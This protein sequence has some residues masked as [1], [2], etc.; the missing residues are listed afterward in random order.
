MFGVLNNGNTTSN[1][2]SQGIVKDEEA[3]FDLDFDNTQPEPKK[4]TVVNQ[5]DNFNLLDLGFD[6]LKPTD[7]N[8]PKVQFSAPVSKFDDLDFL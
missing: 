4:Q 3:I 1:E 7:N 5:T 8:K 6:D 2:N